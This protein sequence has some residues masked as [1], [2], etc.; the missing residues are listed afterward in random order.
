LPSKP[1]AYTGKG[2][3]RRGAILS[4]YSKEIDAAYV[5]LERGNVADVRLPTVW[6]AGELG[7][8]VGDLIYAVMKEH[9][10]E[11]TDI[12]HAGCTR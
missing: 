6:S 7:H 10:G 12:F 8:F 4:D 5:N 1:F 11:S 2:T 9:M 3:P